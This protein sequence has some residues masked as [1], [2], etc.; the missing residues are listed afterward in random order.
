M[1]VIEMYDSQ[2]VRVLL[3]ECAEF[4]QRQLA[5]GKVDPVLIRQAESHVENLRIVADHIHT[6]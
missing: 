5:D 4:I 3:R 2:T 1:T 6:I